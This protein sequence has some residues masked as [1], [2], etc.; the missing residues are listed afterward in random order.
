M[1]QTTLAIW[2]AERGLTR[3]QFAREI[4]MAH[5]TVGALC[6]ERG[7]RWGEPKLSTLRLISQVTG[8]AVETLAREA[9]GDAAQ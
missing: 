7:A 6:G 2:L 3:Y 9:V 1:K 5:H 8:I 4:G